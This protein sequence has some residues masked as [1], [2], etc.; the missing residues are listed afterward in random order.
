[1]RT[2]SARKL[3]GHDVALETDFGDYR[4]TAGV[5]FARTIETGLRG[6]PRRLRVLVDSVETNVPLDDAR[7]K[8]PR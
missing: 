3:R 7:F 6:R 1:V 4:E 8:M 5:R 2:A